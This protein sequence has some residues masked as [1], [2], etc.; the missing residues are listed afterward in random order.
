MNDP[1]RYWPAGI[2]ASIKFS[3]EPIYGPVREGIREHTKAWQLFLEENAVERPPDSGDDLFEVTQR[4]KLVEQWARMSQGDRAASEKRAPVRDSASWYPAHL[5]DRSRTTPKS[6]DFVQFTVPEPLDARSRALWTKLRA[7]LYSLD[8]DSG[9]LFDA[10]D[11]TIGIATLNSASLEASVAPGDFLKWCHVEDADLNA[12]AMTIDGAV[13]CHRWRGSVLF[14]DREALET[15]FV[16]LCE[17]HSN[18]QVQDEARIW[19][20]AIKHEYA[21]WTSLGKRLADSRCDDR[22][23]GPRRVGP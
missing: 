18:G 10:D 7:M 2:P 15:G 12:M 6:V 17:L 3:P 14:V 16:L 20:P 13:I 5:R 8:G 1:Q 22:I 21:R 11:S 9:T 19:A 4:R 23:P